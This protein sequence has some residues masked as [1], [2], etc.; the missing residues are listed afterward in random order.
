MVSLPAPFVFRIEPEDPHPSPYI[1][2][3]L[4]AAIGN[5]LYPS[6]H[7][8]RLRQ[9]WETFYDIRRLPEPARAVYAKLEATIPA[10]VARLIAHQSPTLA[11]RTL[12]QALSDPDRRPARLAELFTAWQPQPQL[13]ADAAPT[14]SFAVLGQARLDGRL[15]PE[16]ESEV[17]SR[18][19]RHWA[20]R[21][22]VDVAEVCAVARR[23]RGG[24]FPLQR[25]VAA[26]PPPALAAAVH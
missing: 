8:G 5:A 13:L 10:F 26:H 16:L 6:P 11:G 17:L 14:L 1:R 22:T 25:A 21:A 23:K 19:L 18:L 15:T 2:V 20:W 9:M 7:W 4:S 12:G 24:V 3:K